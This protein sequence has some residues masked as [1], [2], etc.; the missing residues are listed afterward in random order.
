MTDFH[1]RIRMTHPARVAFLHE[2]DN[3]LIHTVKVMEDRGELLRNNLP[4][5]LMPYQESG[6]AG[7]RCT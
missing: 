1:V 2:V 6:S 4:A 7:G 3:S 5:L